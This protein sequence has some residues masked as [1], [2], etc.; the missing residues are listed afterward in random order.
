MSTA[1]AYALSITDVAFFTPPPNRPS[2][3]GRRNGRDGVVTALLR[4]IRREVSHA[5]E[6][7]D[8]QGMPRITK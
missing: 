3:P 2:R 6:T 5:A 4:T 7:T 8:N 1:G